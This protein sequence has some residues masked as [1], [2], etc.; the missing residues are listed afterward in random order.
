MGSQ[1][2]RDL[3]VWKRGVALVTE[4]YRLTDRFQAGL[5]TG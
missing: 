3:E 2:Y 4:L 5:Y 1:D